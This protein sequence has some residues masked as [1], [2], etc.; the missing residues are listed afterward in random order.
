V[1]LLA[2]GG[3]AAGALLGAGVGSLVPKWR[4]RYARDR[5]LTIRPLIGTGRFG[6]A[7]EF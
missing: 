5:G 1:T 6:F 4:L 2:L 7:L 3:G